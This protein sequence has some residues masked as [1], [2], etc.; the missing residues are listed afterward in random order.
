[1]IELALWMAQMYGIL[2][3]LSILMM[4]SPVYLP[5]FIISVLINDRVKKF[6]TANV[7]M[8]LAL[9]LISSAPYVI[10]PKYVIAALQLPLAMWS[11]LAPL[12]S[13][14]VTIL[15]YKR[16]KCESGNLKT[17]LLKYVIA[18]ATMILVGVVLY[19]T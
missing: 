16:R 2:Y 4:L 7:D 17:P 11:I 13:V 14:C 1:M 18:F 9:S 10:P 15:F 3:P 12:C 8:L 19:L 5:V 6:P